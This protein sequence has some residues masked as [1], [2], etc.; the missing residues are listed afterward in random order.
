MGGARE[1]H[2]SGTTTGAASELEGA[3]E[4]GAQSH[5]QGLP[6]RAGQGRRPTET[7]EWEGHPCRASEVG[8]GALTV[9]A[10]AQL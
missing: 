5:D 6:S 10:A 2:T 1:E 8:M 7:W 9:T 3:C 4:P